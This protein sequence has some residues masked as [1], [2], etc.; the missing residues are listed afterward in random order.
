[1]S[2]ATDLFSP[3][4]RVKPMIQMMQRIGPGG[5]S[6]RIVA[7]RRGVEVVQRWIETT[8]ARCPLACVWIALPDPIAD[9]DEDSDLRW[10]AF[11]WF[12]LKAGCSRGFNK[13]PAPL[14][15]AQ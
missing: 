1:M 8:D 4:R 7:N 12:G 2:P 14:T 10:P 3:E 13:V 5:R 15:L 6:G 9:Q 11:S